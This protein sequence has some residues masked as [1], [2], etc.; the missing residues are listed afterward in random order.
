MTDGGGQ[1]AQLR[2]LV[3]IHAEVDDVQTHAAG[4]G[5]LDHGGEFML[6]GSR[7][8]HMV[9]GDV[10]QNGS[11]IDARRKVGGDRRELETVRNG[12]LPS[13]SS[14]AGAWCI[15]ASKRTRPGCEAWFVRAEPDNST[16][17]RQ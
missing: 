8:G 1:V 17:T 9:G 2:L 6:D 7:R 12:H 16:A 11:H 5:V 13:G 14:G 3:R 4:V 10:H 15:S